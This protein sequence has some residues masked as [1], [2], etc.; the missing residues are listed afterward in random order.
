[1]NFFSSFFHLHLVIF[2]ILLFSTS[3]EAF[4]IL[5]RPKTAGIEHAVLFVPDAFYSGENVRLV[6]ML[7]KCYHADSPYTLPKYIEFVNRFRDRFPGTIVITNENYI[8]EIF[9]RC[10][11]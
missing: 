7:I 6:T 1:M 11:P 8:N 9:Q 5:F 3:T 4:Y 2:L 10:E